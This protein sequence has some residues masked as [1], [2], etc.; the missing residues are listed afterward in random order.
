M[1][2]EIILIL[3]IL[4]AI[5]CYFW[6]QKITEE[7]PMVVSE[8][9][10][11]SES[12]EN[13]SKEAPSIESKTLLY[14]TEFTYE[15]VLLGE[16]NIIKLINT[17]FSINPKENIESEEIRIHYN[18]IIASDKVDSYIE[19]YEKAKNEYL[20]MSV[21]DILIKDYN[22]K[23]INVDGKILQVMEYDVEFST[24]DNIHNTVQRRQ[25]FHLVKEDGIIKI[26]S[27]QK[28]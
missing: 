1:K 8:R 15:E 25:K 19:I 7:A 28:A 10:G 3:A 9:T 14:E 11:K 16:Q 13:Q 6:Y 12:E 23:K 5:G 18:E 21:Q 22:P 4:T 17:M 24:T 27:N 2:K 26:F 20:E